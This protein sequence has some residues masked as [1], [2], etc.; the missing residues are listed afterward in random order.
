MKGGYTSVVLNPFPGEFASDRRAFLMDEV[1]K[2]VVALEDGYERSAITV[3]TFDGE[4]RRV[5]LVVRNPGRWYGESRPSMKVYDERGEVIETRWP[6]GEMPEAGEKL[7]REF[8]EY[9]PVVPDW[10]ESLKEWARASI[11]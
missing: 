11:K 7:F 10:V 5:E 6:K 2:V 9:L 4:N 1:G 3:K 8:T